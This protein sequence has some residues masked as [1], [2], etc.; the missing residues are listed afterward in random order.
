VIGEDGESEKHQSEEEK[1][2][3]YLGSYMPTFMG[4]KSKNKNKKQLD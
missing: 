1:Q 2:S 3:S 4:G